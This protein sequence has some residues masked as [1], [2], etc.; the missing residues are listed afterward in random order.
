[1]L[2]PCTTC[3]LWQDM[4]TLNTQAP[5]DTMPHK[6]MNTKVEA[7]AA[8]VQ[9]QAQGALHTKPPAPACARHHSYHR[10]LPQPLLPQQL[11]HLRL[12]VS[13]VQHSRGAAQEGC[14]CCRGHALLLREVLK[15]GLQLALH[16]HLCADRQTGTQ[17]KPGQLVGSVTKL[18]SICNCDSRSRCRPRDRL[19]GSRSRG[20]GSIVQHST[21]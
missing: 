13:A 7:A 20:L 1:M 10:Q 21:R 14:C 18:R 3:Q 9:A 16:I 6:I 2:R 17:S 5:H 19:G 11:L 12:V 8:V 15:D 4:Y